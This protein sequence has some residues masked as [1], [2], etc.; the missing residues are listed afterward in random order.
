MGDTYA[1]TSLHSCGFSIVLGM[2][3]ISFCFLDFLFFFYP[4]LVES[5]DVKPVD[6]EGRLYWVI[7]TTGR[8]IKPCFE[9]TGTKDVLGLTA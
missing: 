1:Y 2:R 5:V 7:H 3:Q 4:Q 9:K 8:K 6:M